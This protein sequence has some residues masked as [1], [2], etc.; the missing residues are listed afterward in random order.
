L[1]SGKYASVNS[2]I[3][4]EENIMPD[5]TDEEYDALAS[6]PRLSVDGGS[7]QIC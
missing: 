1:S 2:G 5:M 6:P 7:R 3:V 4:R